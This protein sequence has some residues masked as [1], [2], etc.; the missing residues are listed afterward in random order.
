MDDRNHRNTQ[1]PGLA[2]LDYLI[3]GLMFVDRKFIAVVHYN[4]FVQQLLNFLR[5]R[6]YIGLM[7][8]GI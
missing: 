3:F 8:K 7:D 5:D 4:T 6:I 2:F 1:V